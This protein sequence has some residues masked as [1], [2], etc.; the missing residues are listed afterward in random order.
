MLFNVH[1]IVR[2]EWL[3]KQKGLRIALYD[4]NACKAYLTSTLPSRTLWP[5]YVINALPAVSAIVAVALVYF[6]PSKFG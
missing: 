3:K 6:W 4:D 2:D 5:L 1:R